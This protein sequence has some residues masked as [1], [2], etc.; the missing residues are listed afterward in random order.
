M[1]APH[2]C[3]HS[4]NTQLLQ[5]AVGKQKKIPFAVPIIR[6]EPTDHIT[7]CYFCLTN[8]KGFSKKNKFKI[9]YS[10]FQSAL[11]PVPHGTDIPIPKAS[12]PEVFERPEFLS[13]PD[14]SS[15]ATSSDLEVVAASS[16]TPVCINQSMLNDLVRDLA[17]P[18]CKAEILGLNFNQWNLLETK[19]SEF[20]LR[21]EKLCSSFDSYNGL[22]FCNDVDGLMMEFGYKHKCDEW[23]LFIDS[24]K[25]SLKAVLLRNGNT[26]PSIHLAHAIQLKGGH[27][28]IKVLLDAL[29]YL[30]YSGKICGDLKVISL[31]LGLQ[32]YYTKYTVM[33]FLCLWNSRDDTNH[34]SKVGTTRSFYCRQI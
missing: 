30:K 18:K 20:R 27:E 32:L 34:F 22:S 21:N 4:C 6:R 15:E 25:A 26:H 31:I 10:S 16:N 17:L 5:W 19:I 23:R 8:I 11:K 12:S 13:E 14:R 29:Q 24:S 28:T 3:C 33:C 9:V 2:I 7:D 1:R